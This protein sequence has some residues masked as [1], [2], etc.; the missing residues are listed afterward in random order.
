MITIDLSTKRKTI[1]L[2]EILF[3][4]VWSSPVNHFLISRYCC[5]LWPGTMRLNDLSVCLGLTP[6]IKLWETKLFIVCPIALLSCI[7]RFRVALQ[8]P[9]R[10]SWERWWLFS[11][12]Q[13]LWGRVL[14]QL[15]ARG[16]LH[17]ILRLQA[18]GMRLRVRTIGL[19]PFLTPEF[20]YPLLEI[21]DISLVSTTTNT[22][23]SNTYP[24]KIICKFLRDTHKMRQSDLGIISRWL[25]FL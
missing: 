21:V 9:G 12:A 5:K 13:L 3:D 6:T 17:A 14:S 8:H 20:I 25:F 4:R 22:T 10:E 11:S 24:A 23:T 1:T 16:N 19:V 15:H 18:F 7:W 2:L